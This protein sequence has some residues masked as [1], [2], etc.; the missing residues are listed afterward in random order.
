MKCELE[1]YWLGCST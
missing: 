1:M